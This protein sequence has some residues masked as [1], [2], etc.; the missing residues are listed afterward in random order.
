MDLSVNALSGLWWIYKIQLWQ[1]QT[2]WE[3]SVC[4]MIVRLQTYTKCADFNNA[5]CVFW[6]KP[7]FVCNIVFL[8]RSSLF[9]HVSSLFSLTVSEK[10][11]HFAQLGL[12][13]NN[14]RIVLLT[15]SFCNP[16]PNTNEQTHY[17]LVSEQKVDHSWAFL[18][19]T[20]LFGGILSN[21]SAFIVWSLNPYPSG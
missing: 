11:L 9:F 18:R 4:L 7:K 12:K 15:A 13:V 14:N 10:R 20:W 2:Y 1:Y 16:S 21:T 5:D 19:Q 6:K 8:W 3:L 17:N